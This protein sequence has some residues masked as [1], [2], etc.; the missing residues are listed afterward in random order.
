MKEKG[1]RLPAG[2]EE[3]ERQGLASPF[4]VRERA[5]NSPRDSS[6][7]VIVGGEIPY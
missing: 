5:E 2:I 7:W 6:S 1:K 4:E 3:R